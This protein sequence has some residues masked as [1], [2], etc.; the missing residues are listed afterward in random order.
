MVHRGGPSC[1]QERRSQQAR[2]PV[3]QQPFHG[4][5]IRQVSR[6]PVLFPAAFVFRNTSISLHRSLKKWLSMYQKNQIA[7]NPGLA[8]YKPSGGRQQRQGQ[9]GQGEAKGSHQQ[10]KK[11]RKTSKSAQGRTVLF[12]FLCCCCFFSR[13]SFSQIRPSPPRRFLLLVRASSLTPPLP[14][15]NRPAPTRYG[16]RPRPGLASSSRRRTSSPPCRRRPAGSESSIQEARFPCAGEER[17]RLSKQYDFF[18]YRV[19]YVTRGVTV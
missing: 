12:L 9:H 15:P 4:H 8:N 17:E 19:E 2:G 18:T 14:P 10:Q 3:A 13:K 7:F 5:A 1:K 6:Q 16:T 11:V